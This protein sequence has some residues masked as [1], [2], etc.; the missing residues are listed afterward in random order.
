LRLASTRGTSSASSSSSSS[1]SST[2]LL[3]D[4]TD[5]TSS[6]HVPVSAPDAS[7]SWLHGTVT[8]HYS[9]SV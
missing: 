5:T 6:S 4:T 7:V 1:S 9:Q 8:K 2:S 3:R